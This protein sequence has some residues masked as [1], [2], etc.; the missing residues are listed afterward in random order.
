MLRRSA[1]FLWKYKK[2]TLVA[3]GASYAGYRYIK[4]QRENDAKMVVAPES[5]LTWKIVD[6]LLVESS[7]NI[8]VGS[9][10]F[11][12]SMLRKAL[13]DSDEVT[14]FDALLSLE[15]AAKDPRIHEICINLTNGSKDSQG[16]PGSAG[17]SLTQAQELRAALLAFTEQKKK[18]LGPTAGRV[19]FVV[20][21]FDDQTT[22]LLASGCSDIIAQPSG[23]LPLT[24][25][26]STQLFF[27]RLADKIGVKPVVESRKEYK[28]FASTF[29]ETKLPVKQRENMVAIINAINNMLVDDIAACKLHG[30]KAP[31]TAEIVRSAMAE[32]PLSVPEAIDRG[33]LS[34]SGYL[35]DSKSIT[36][37]K[38]RI[39]ITAY[40]LVREKEMSRQSDAKKKDTVCIVYMS[41]TIRRN[42]MHSASS[43]A[44]ALI[45]AAK[46][47]S[48]SALVFRIDSGGG[49]A[50]ASDTIAHA[51][52]HIQNE[53]GKPVVASYGSA[54]ASG[55]VL[56]SITCRKIFANPGSITGSI[57][58]V[59][60]KPVFTKK[61]LDYLGVNVEELRVVDNRSN[62]FTEEPTGAELE[63]FRARVDKIYDYFVARVA[64]GRGFTPEQA[65]AVARGQVFTGIQAKDN[66]LVDELGSLTRAVEAAAQL[67]HK[68]TDDGYK[69]D[70]T[71]NI[72]VKFCVPETNLGFKHLAKNFM[73][74]A[75]HEEAKNILLQ[76]TSQSDI[77]LK[78]D[79]I[80]LK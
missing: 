14:I 22:Y 61:L 66:G 33:L 53:L 4:I 3:A 67:G 18:Q 68:G 23:Y 11:L 80:F 60:M 36:G 21:S 69:A 45:K 9:L 30:A 1:A 6:G 57:G 13:I 56:A 44:S 55:A 79:D 31:L 77:D 48:V 8:K 65:E 51:I 26:S 74:Q 49:D 28:G 20:D 15:L 63:R 73:W 46:E 54:A 70:I 16:S 29:T 71:E 75:M 34:R 59:A 19:Y 27:R 12:G 2:T 39:G 52:D 7:K 42:G 50:I 47:P 17:I 10:G 76:N 5:V 32:G 40:R 24:G 64:K 58:V 25:V 78:L 35:L 41:G 72:N 37:P 43:L 38:S 62:S